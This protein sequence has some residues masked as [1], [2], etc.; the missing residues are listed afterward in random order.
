MENKN[1]NCSLTKMSSGYI[2][3]RTIFEGKLDL[4]DLYPLVLSSM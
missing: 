3:M 4:L 1:I 2:E